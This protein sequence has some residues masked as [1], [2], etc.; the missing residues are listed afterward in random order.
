ML[1]TNVFLTP[2][3]I[4]KI[5]DPDKKTQ[6]AKA[7]QMETHTVNSS[8]KET[9][10]LSKTAFE[11]E[12]HSLYLDKEKKYRFHIFSDTTCI[13]TQVTNDLETP[14]PLLFRLKK[15]Y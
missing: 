2:H 4:L 1:D 7:L 10:F 11:K 5:Q 15:T 3:T 14:H 6:A 13:L 8:F 12:S 9:L